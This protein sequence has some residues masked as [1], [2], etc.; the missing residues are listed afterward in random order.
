MYGVATPQSH[1][2]SLW[3]VFVI[4][5]RHTGKFQDLSGRKIMHSN[6]LV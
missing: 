2:Q 5:H 1:S 3:P 6:L 4:G